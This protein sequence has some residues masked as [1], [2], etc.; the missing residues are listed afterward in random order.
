MPN[1]PVL[2]LSLSD[3]PLYIPRPYGRSL[4][5]EGCLGCYFKK[6]KILK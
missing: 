1:N 2:P 4:L 5:K 6:I 3:E